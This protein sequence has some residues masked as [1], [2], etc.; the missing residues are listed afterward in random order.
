MGESK[1]KMK[2]IEELL[3]RSGA[4]EQYHE[5]EFWV[6]SPETEG[7]ALEERRAAALEMITR[8][9]DVVGDAVL[10][11]FRKMNASSH[12]STMAML[13]IIG[14]ELKTRYGD[15]WRMI[16]EVADRIRDRLLMLCTFDVVERGP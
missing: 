15:D 4:I 1:R 8:E 10:A 14:G 3:N 11:V 12:G 9:V 2:L 6:L 5:P 13:T 7:Q 16:E